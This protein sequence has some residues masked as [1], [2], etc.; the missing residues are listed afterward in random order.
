MFDIASPN[1][2]IEVDVGDWAG[3]AGCL[4]L[5]IGR[6]SIV[7]FEPSGARGAGQL[8]YESGGLHGTGHRTGAPTLHSLIINQV[9]ECDGI[10]RLANGSTNQSMNSSYKEQFR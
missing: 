9:K 6:V 5:T 10:L 4:A 2:N 8:G 3:G 1:L 7:G